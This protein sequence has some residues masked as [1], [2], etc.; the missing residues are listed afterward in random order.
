MDVY[1]IHCSKHTERLPNI[2][3]H[4]KTL[5][6]QLKI[7]EGTYITHSINNVE[8]E[9][10]LYTPE[11]RVKNKN[12]F[13]TVGEIGCYLSHHNLLKHI[14]HQHSNSKYTLILEDDGMLKDDVV[15]LEEKLEKIPFDIFYLGLNNEN[16]GTHISSD[17]YHINNS[18]YVTGTHAY[19]INNANINK[20]YES[21]LCP[22]GPIDHHYE[23]CIKNNTINAVITYPYL[24]IQDRESFHST[25]KY[26]SNTTN[27]QRKNKITTNTTALLTYNNEQEARERKTKNNTRIQKLI[28]P[29]VISKGINN[30]SNEPVAPSR[31]KRTKCR[32]M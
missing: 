18:M 26:Q 3:Y 4:L 21:T 22:I 20:V 28:A 16:K 14:K 29:I 8:K 32:P 30:A 6:P 11:I 17:I 5:F 10:Q 25:I 7:W 13:K 15:S 1:V 27:R 19:V 12:I 24:C 2:D 23:V 31:R 9:L